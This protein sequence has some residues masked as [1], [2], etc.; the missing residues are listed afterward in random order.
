MKQGAPAGSQSGIASE[1]NRMVAILTLAGGI[2]AF[3]A[4]AAFYLIPFIT[5]D[6]ELSDASVG[7]IGSAVTIGW[8]ISGFFL[9]QIS[10]ATQRRKP[11]LIGAFLGVGVLSAFSAMATN[12]ITLFV[13]RLGIGLAEGPIIP[14]KQYIVM[15][16]SSPRRVG[17]N[18][19][20]VQNFGGNLLGA[21]AAPIV[22]VA[23]ALHFGWR[24][25]FLL[26][27]VP[28]FIVALLIY[29]YIKEPPREE[30]EGSSAGLIDWGKLG[31]VSRNRNVRIATAATSCIVAWHIL[32][33]TFMPLWFTRDLGY[34][35]SN[36]SLFMAIV[37][38]AG[39][40]SAIIV[41][42][43]SDRIGRK[44]T[45]GIF[46]A[47]GILAPLSS[48][49]FPQSPAIISILLFLGCFTFGAIPVVMST[50]PMESV[51]L[52]MRATAVALVL[53]TGQLLGGVLGPSLGGRLADSLGPETPLIMAAGFA[54]L[55]AIISLLLSETRPPAD[56]SDTSEGL[57]A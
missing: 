49:I 37:G 12:F 50:V 9:S 18:M 19:G 20:I 48:V 5:E 16:G 13:A 15:A 29:R 27:A 34:T 33:L 30:K 26:A 21:L 17:M 45:I 39:V 53:G 4:G 14:V 47:I 57:S 6:F 11:F 56:A 55:A 7:L 23:M 54:G 25:A 31:Q 32:M 28:A 1:E 40:V 38:L 46:S 22:M 8:A 52:G 51:S 36:M 24:A 35:P 3:D 42:G 10:D 44:P 41:P 2:A 43:I